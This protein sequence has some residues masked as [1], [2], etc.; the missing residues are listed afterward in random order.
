MIMDAVPS[1]LFRSELKALFHAASNVF[2]EDEFRAA[3]M[4][5]D[6]WDLGSKFWP[7]AVSTAF[8]SKP[9]GPPTPGDMRFGEIIS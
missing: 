4:R 8:P 5:C 3:A 1:A 9:S 6:A 2:L 7:A